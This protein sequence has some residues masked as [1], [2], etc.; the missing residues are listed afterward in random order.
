MTSE[1]SNTFKLNEKE[2]SISDLNET[3]RAQYSSLVFVDT[4]LQ[5]LSNMQA[6]LQRSKNSYLADLK[7]EMLSNKAGFLIDE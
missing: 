7:K 3:A 2:Y 5:E 6:L 1:N 4:K